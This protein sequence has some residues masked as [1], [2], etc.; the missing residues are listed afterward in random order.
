MLL[1]ITGM[2][3]FAAIEMAKANQQLVQITQNQAL[4][5]IKELKRNLIIEVSRKFIQSIQACLKREKQFLESGFFITLY[6]VYRREGKNE[7]IHN[8]RPSEILKNDNLIPDTILQKYLEQIHQLNKKF[9]DYVK[10]LELLLQ[11]IYE[12][13]EMFIGEFNI[14]CTT[15][16]NPDKTMARVI[17]EDKEDAIFVMALADSNHEEY[18]KYP[19]FNHNREVLISKL[20]DM[21]LEQEIMEYKKITKTFSE[22]EQEYQMLFNKLYRDWKEEYSVTDAELGLDF[23]G[24]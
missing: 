5:Q 4:L 14:Y 18:T 8:N 13:K 21:G 10:N 9:D 2:S 22:I 11:K 12:K 16:P 15:L 1:V 19:F 6:G 17:I 7:N 3:T 20:C 24:M 23:N